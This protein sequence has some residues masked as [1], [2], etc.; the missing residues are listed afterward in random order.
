[1]YLCSAISVFWYG[2]ILTAGEWTYLSH[3]LYLGSLTNFFLSLGR[4]RKHI[5][6]EFEI[7]GQVVVM[8]GIFLTF[9]DTWYF[10]YEEVTPHELS[11][12][13]NYY[14]TRTRSERLI[15]DIVN[16]LLYIVRYQCWHRWLCRFRPESPPDSTT[17]TLP[18]SACSSS[19]SWMF[20]TWRP[21]RTSS[22]ESPLILPRAGAS[23]QSS[24]TMSSPGWCTAE[25]CFA[26]GSF[27]A[28]FWLPS[29][30]PTSWSPVS[31]T[32]S[33]LDCLASSLTLLKCKHYLDL[34]LWWVTP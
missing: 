10:R 20:S 23:S 8:L 11:C 7:G 29:C 33:S 17:A 27:Y 32:S 14:L 31:L 2:M 19:I 25:L 21:S 15:F 26:L 5:C 6:H 18:S 30:S 12:R 16:T 28:L 3:A 4:H 22:M 13:N 1:M 9:I 34:S 24:P